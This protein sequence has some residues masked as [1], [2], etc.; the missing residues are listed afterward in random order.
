IIDEDH[1][2]IVIADVVGKGVPASIFAMA[3]KTVI[4]MSALDGHSPMEV[5]AQ[6]NRQLCEN[7]NEMMFSTTWFGIYTISERKMVYANAG[8]NDPLLMRAAEGR[9]EYLSD[10]PDMALGVMEG[11]PYTEHTVYLSPGDKMFLYTDGVVEAQKPENE[12]LGHAKKKAEQILGAA[13]DLKLD[14]VLYGDERL[15]ASLNADVSRS[16][17]AVLDTVLSDVRAFVGDEPQ[18]DDITMLVF[19]IF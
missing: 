4:K 3:A 12:R 10:E 6:T 13:T 19:E 14:M 9:Y 2:A 17:D 5:C 1:T 16:G 8:H 18:F 11:L 15:R 7:N